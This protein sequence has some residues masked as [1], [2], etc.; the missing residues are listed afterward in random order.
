MAVGGFFSVGPPELVLLNTSLRVQYH[1]SRGA[2]AL[3]V[4][5]G[6]VVVAWSMTKLAFRL[7]CGVFGIGTLLGSLHLFLYQLEAKDAGL[8]WRDFYGSTAIGWRD[9]RRV[10]QGAGG[11][12]ITGPGDIRIP[13][14]TTD[15][16]PEQRASLERSISRRVRES[17]GP[18]VTAPASSVP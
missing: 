14:D 7:L 5:A 10:E 8:V 4:T 12:M 16:E 13:V 1:W 9:V 18:P 3:L 11:L 2:G 15:F 17:A 6:L